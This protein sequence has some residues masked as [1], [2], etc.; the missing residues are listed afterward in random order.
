MCKDY[1]KQKIVQETHSSEFKGIEESENHE[2]EKGIAQDSRSN[3]ETA[4][5]NG[6]ARLDAA[7]NAELF[8]IAGLCH[9]RW[10]TPVMAR[11]VMA[12][13]HRPVMNRQPAPPEP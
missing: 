8:G 10:R 3:L 2:N 9:R 13:G 5:L 6:S 4:C 7:V 12:K 11:S 1:K